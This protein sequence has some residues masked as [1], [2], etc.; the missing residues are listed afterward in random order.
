MIRSGRGIRVRMVGALG[1][2]YVALVVLTRPDFGV[3]TEPLRRGGA[4]TARTFVGGLIVGLLA[5]VYSERCD[6]K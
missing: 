1:L 5:A 3:L 2:V 4:V 6:E